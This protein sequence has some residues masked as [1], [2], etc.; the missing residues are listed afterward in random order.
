MELTDAQYDEMVLLST[1][2]WNPRVG[3]SRRVGQIYEWIAIS[4]FVIAILGCCF[5]IG[6]LSFLFTNVLGVLVVAILCIPVV[7]FRVR[8]RQFQHVVVRNDF[9]LCPWCQYV[10]V[11]LQDS[12]LCPE[13]G[14]PYER[15]LCRSLYQLSYAPTERD[16]KKKILAERRA[17]RRAILLRDGAIEPSLNEPQRDSGL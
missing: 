7:W 8:R 6:P 17:W 4:I 11:D 5:P 1:G 13:C 9:F 14:S 16:P 15:A 3:K 2:R 10:L 12:G